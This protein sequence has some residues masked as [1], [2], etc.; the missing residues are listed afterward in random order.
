MECLY[1]VVF[2]KVPVDDGPE[3]VNNTLMDWNG[4][5]NV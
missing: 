4:P 5:E 1:T 3:I 2:A